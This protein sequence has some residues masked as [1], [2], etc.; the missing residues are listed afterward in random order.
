[1]T[2][3]R[4]R[5]EKAMQEDEEHG[6]HPLALGLL[7]GT[8]VGAAVGLLLA[9]RKGSE[10]RKQVGEQLVHAKDACATGLHKAT[11]TVGDLAHRSRQAY[12]AT[13]ERV[14]NGAQGTWRYVCDV[15]DAVTMKSR[16]QHEGAAPLS[17]EL[18]SKSN[19]P[20]DVR[21]RARSAIAHAR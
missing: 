19:P 13:S 9:P 10:T 14:V 1:M 3:E 8:A 5:V 17:S 11:D 21:E 20:A 12:T 7:A 15:A 6:G 2:D 18:Q 4:T 16:R